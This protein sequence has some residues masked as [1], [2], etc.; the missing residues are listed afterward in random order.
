MGRFRDVGRKLQHTHVSSPFGS[1][2][3]QEGP[4]SAARGKAGLAG[5]ISFGHRRGKAEGEAGGASS[6]PSPRVAGC[7]IGLLFQQAP[8]T[9]PARSRRSP[10]GWRN[11]HR[12]R[13]L[14]PHLSEYAKQ[15]DIRILR[16]CRCA[17]CGRRGLAWR[18]FS[19]RAGGTPSWRS[20]S[21]VAGPGKP[22]SQPSRP[23]D[24]GRI[25]P[26]V[27]DHERLPASRLATVR[28]KRSARPSGICSTA[29][30]SCSTR[31]VRTAAACCAKRWPACG[32][33]RSARIAH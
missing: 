22:T 12:R 33:T 19:T 18:P 4:G 17:R 31:T 29:A 5:R 26:R 21:R 7:P 15:T 9:T 10:A 13:R 32:T 6:P 20:A 14:A 1:G 8:A 25:D 11:G 24:D 27:C 2:Q 16:R 3:G 28:R 30:S 23:F